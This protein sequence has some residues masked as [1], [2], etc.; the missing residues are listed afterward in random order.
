MKI[1]LCI[2]FLWL[3]MWTSSA[4]EPNY[5][6]IADAIYRIEGGKKAEFPYGIRSVKVKDEAEARRVCINTIRNNYARWVAAGRPIDFLTFLG[7]HYCPKASDPV[8]HDNWV[9][10]IHKIIYEKIS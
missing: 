4:A 6:K 7:D 5:E 10:N 1:L 9:R 8:G 3:C 2:I